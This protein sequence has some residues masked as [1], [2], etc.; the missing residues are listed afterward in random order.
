MDESP[1]AFEHSVGKLAKRTGGRE[2]ERGWVVE[3]ERRKE[4]FREGG[5]GAG[6]DKNGGAGEAT[7]GFSYKRIRNLAGVGV[8]RM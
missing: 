2:T 7:S 5:C 1:R 3:A 6:S 4:T 8:G